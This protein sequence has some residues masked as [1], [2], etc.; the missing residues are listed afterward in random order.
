MVLKRK[1]EAE[2]FTSVSEFKGKGYAARGKQHQDQQQGALLGVQEALVT[3][4]R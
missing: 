2:I 1:G 3:H 4:L